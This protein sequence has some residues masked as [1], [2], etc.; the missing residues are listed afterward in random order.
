MCSTMA[1]R[2]IIVH[3]DDVG[4]SH[5]ANV[6]MEELWRSRSITSG[7]IIVPTGWFP[8]TVEMASRHPDMDLGIHL[9]VTS[10]S[11][12]FRW[13]PLTPAASTGGLTDGDGYLWPTT[14]QVRRHADPTA[15]ESELRSQID[16]AIEA[17]IDV[18]HLDHHM[19]AALAPE[20]V[21][22]TAR[23]ARDYRLPILFPPDLVRYFDDVKLDAHN[24]EHTAELREDLVREGL[25]I[26]DRFLMGLN[27]LDSTV[28][29]VFADF[30]ARAADGTTFVSLHASAP[31]DIMAVHPKDGRWRIDE[32]ETLRTGPVAAFAAAGLEPIGFRE[33]RDTI[34][35]S[36]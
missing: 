18:T 1:D 25:A 16:T 36:G 30:A 2:S 28:D 4:C 10:E 7:S 33:L 8:A 27:H 23:I 21:E 12:G 32:Y 9:A 13:R 29:R 31:T 3:L 22:G 17:G 6:A 20:F 26:A 24:L 35:V 11:A 5:G 34:R 15:V 14:D 19:G